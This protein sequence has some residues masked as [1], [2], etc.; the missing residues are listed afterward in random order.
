MII[1]T[2]M[3]F[4]K[5]DVFGRPY[6]KEGVLS[7]MDKYHIDKA[8]LISD[9]A[10]SADFMLGNKELYEVI[11]SSDRL[12]GYLAVNPNYPDEAIE[13]MK[14]VMSSKKFLAAAFF[15]GVGSPYANVG[16][17]RA[18]LNAYRRYGKPVFIDTPNRTA[19]EAA[20]E[21]AKEFNTIKFIFGSMG[22]NDWQ[23]AISN[24][25][26]LNV[27]LETSG[28]FDTDKIKAAFTSFGPHRIMFGS[29]APF[30][31][32]ASMLGLVKNSGL[33]DNAAAKIL[34]ANAV[35]ILGVDNNNSS[36]ADE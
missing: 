21:I 8:V 12:Y 11:S 5:Y 1:D 6:G 7:L 9:I 4:C 14:S 28:S 26:L 13:L 3:N 32:P 19:I 20:E 2:R 10:V 33:S 29:N 17:Y 23:R 30:S 22:G 35:S 18:I 34:S 24:N 15:Q 27:C 16:D 31:D 25:K 36:L